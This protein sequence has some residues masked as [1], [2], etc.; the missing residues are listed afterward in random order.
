[1]SSKEA[2]LWLVESRVSI[3]TGVI[4]IP[5]PDAPKKDFKFYLRHALGPWNPSFWTSV[6]VAI[7]EKDLDI[8]LY[9][10]DAMTHRASSRSRIR[11]KKTLPSWTPRSQ[12]P[13]RSWACLSTRS[14][15]DVGGRRS[16]RGVATENS[17]R[18]C[19]Q[20]LSGEAASAPTAVQ[21]SRGEVDDLRESLITPRS[22]KVGILLVDARL[23]T[24]RSSGLCGGAA[25]AMAEPVD[26]W[27]RDDAPL[28]RRCDG[29][30][31]G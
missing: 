20:R 14:G 24:G 5:A 28:R 1:M 8:Y 16:V 13:G 11:R 25:V 23:A 22:R 18:R 3:A 4:P 29:P 19:G 30:R 2:V 31:S 15:S 9:G 12:R 21:R 27:D 17:I 6:A 7:R 10:A 26:L